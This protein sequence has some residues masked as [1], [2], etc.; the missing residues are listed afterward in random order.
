MQQRPPMIISAS[1]RTDIPC[2]Y[3]KWLVNRLRKNF[4]Y[5]ANPFNGKQ[6]S[7]VTLTPELVDCLVFWTKN[8]EPFFA[9]LPQIDSMG[10]HYYFQFTLTSYDANLEQGVPKKKTVIDTFKKLSDII[11]AEKVIWRYD[12]ILMTDTYNDYYHRKWFDYLA[13]QLHR[14]TRKCSIS[15]LHLYKKCERNLQDIPLHQLTPD[16]RKQLTEGFA[17]IA[18]KY[19][20]KL[21]SCALTE[22][23][24][25]LGVNPG[26]CVDDSLAATITGRDIGYKKD[27]NQRS[28]CCCT[29]SVDIGSY[30]S[31]LNFCRYCYANS[32]ERLVRTNVRTHDPASPLLIGTVPD[33]AKISDRLIRL[34]DKRQLAL[35]QENGHRNK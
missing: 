8:P 11:G 24:R 4:V 2:Y 25:H 30:N 19:S 27:R 10:Y 18:G 7:R 12:P 3:G 29:E 16:R 33:D 31:C 22:D 21:E 1:R 17:E 15:F 35:F 13:G 32:S 34:S 9:Q 28:Q 26:R 14:Y 6:V 20:L 5:V 23:Y